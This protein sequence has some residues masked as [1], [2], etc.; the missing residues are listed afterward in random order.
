MVKRISTSFFTLLLLSLGCSSPTKEQ[1]QK[2]NQTQEV[3][4]VSEDK[5]KNSE[6]VREKNSTNIAVT[7]FRYDDIEYL[8]FRE[9]HEDVGSF[10]IN[11]A[12]YCSHDTIEL[13]GRTWV[14][15]TKPSLESFFIKNR[16]P[17]L[18]K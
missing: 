10:I 12:H 15:I 13:C 1:T 8:Y 5:S 6:N 9:N 14:A 16:V 4:A 3:K 18:E 2:T 7:S 11:P 17:T